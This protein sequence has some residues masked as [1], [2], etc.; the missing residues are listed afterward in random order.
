[1]QEVSPPQLPVTANAGDY[2]ILKFLQE[3]VMGKV[4][5]GKRKRDKKE[6]AMK[7]FGYTR[8]QPRLES[9]LAEITIMKSLVGIEGVIQLEDV[10]MDTYRGMV[11]GRRSAV[12]Y[13]V[14]VMELCRGSDFFDRINTR[15]SV[16]ERALAQL[17]KSVTIAL[18]SLHARRFIHRDLKPENLMLAEDCENSPVKL[19]DFGMMVQLDPGAD[20]FIDDT[21]RGTPGYFAPESLGHPSKYSMKSDMWQLGCILYST[22][23]GLMAFG[24]NSKEQIAMGKYEE[25]TGYGWDGISAAAK[26]LVSKMLVVNPSKR[27]G[28]DEVLAHPWVVTGGAPNVALG[29]DYMARVKHLALRQK[30]KKFFVESNIVSTNQVRR[31]RLEEA[32]PLLASGDCKALF[33]QTVASFFSRLCTLKR[34]VLHAMRSAPDEDDTEPPAKKKI[35]PCTDQLDYDTFVNAMKQAELPELGCPQVFRIFDIDGSGSIDLKEFLLTMIAFRPFPNGGKCSESARDAAALYFNVFDLN[36]NGFIDLEEMKLVVSCF[37]LDEMEKP[38]SI[39]T[40]PEEAVKAAQSPPAEG[41]GTKKNADTQD[42]DV[43]LNVETV[44]GLFKEFDKSKDGQID[45]EEFLQ[46]YEALLRSSSE[47]KS[48]MSVC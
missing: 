20:S 9:V 36:D 11:V 43:A 31:Q 24:P 22:L 19:I 46:V 12:A 34:V 26:D 28:T 33:G 27:L 15:S 41:N 14:I 13:P 47:R 42:S 8:Q 3:G 38:S 37:L 1:M 35:R 25:M 30:L 5:R 21:V 29:A 44:E 17:F 48:L 4:F 39:L 23:S 18:S 2:T 32:I 10:F 7:F 40:N 45:F 16:S 6:V